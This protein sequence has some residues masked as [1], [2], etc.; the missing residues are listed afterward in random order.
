[1]KSKTLLFCTSYFRDQQQWLSR[2]A[3]WLEHHQAISWPVDAVAVIDDGSP[4]LPQSEAVEPIETASLGRVPLPSRSLVR[5]KDNLGRPSTLQYPGWWRSFQLALDLSEIYGF[6]KVIH[7]ESDSYLLSTRILE[8]IEATNTGWTLFWSEHFGLPESAIQIICHDVFNEYAKIREKGP[9]GLANQFAE[10]FLPYTRVVKHFTGDRYNDFGATIPRDADYAVQVAPEMPTAVPDSWTRRLKY[11]TL[12]DP[13]EPI[14]PITP[15]SPAVAPDAARTNTEPA[16]GSAA[17]QRGINAYQRGDFA[18]AIDE[19]I[20]AR[21]LAPEDAESHKFLAASLMQV[22]RVQE[23]IQSAE[24]AAALAPGDAG[25]ANMLGAFYASANDGV[26]AMAEWCRAIDLNPADLTVLQNITVIETRLGLTTQ[27]SQ[28]RRE[29]MTEW[30]IERLASGDFSRPTLNSLLRIWD[31]STVDRSKLLQIIA[32][33]CKSI[34]V[35]ST[36]EAYGL[37]QAACAA[38]DRNRASMFVE[39]LARA[40]NASAEDRRMYEELQLAMSKIH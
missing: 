13:R 27:T 8:F 14:A 35:F 3:R 6:T 12:A 4:I 39:P 31:P 11:K 16:D 23:A 15:V 1:V 9:H 36:E 7:V 25:L 32:S 17:R 24:R 30:M 21:Q 37:A 22:K 19:L 38:G 40:A 34:D 18:L 10:N 33:A 28:Q 5:F 20:K 29:F 2:Y 26:R